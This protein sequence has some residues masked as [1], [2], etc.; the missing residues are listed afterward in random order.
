[1]KY[2]DVRNVL[3]ALAGTKA[4]VSAKNIKSN[5]FKR[6]ISGILRYRYNDAE[7]ALK[8]VED[9][10]N[11]PDEFDK[12]NPE[13]H[14]SKIMGLNY[15]NV[16][17]KDVGITESEISKA[18][19]GA[20]TEHKL[21]KLAWCAFCQLLP[22]INRIRI[23][24]INGLGMA[25]M[26]KRVFHYDKESGMGVLVERDCSKMIKLLKEYRRLGHIIDTKH[27]EL[28][29]QW[30]EYKQKIVSLEKWEKYLGI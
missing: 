20:N 21:M 13:Q 30:A 7:A 4:E 1:M 6:V 25:N 10:Y 15:K 22:S 11:G 8:A 9:Y 28:N 19:N 18:I 24:E 29:S 12:L 3:I 23:A 14:H 26:S 27:D 5:L 17:V 2:Y 16:P